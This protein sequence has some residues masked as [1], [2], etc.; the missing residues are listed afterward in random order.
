[1]VASGRSAIAGAGVG[2]AVGD[3]VDT[4]EVAVALSLP[5]ACVGSG[6]VVALG[7]PREAVALDSGDVA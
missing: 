7:L 2:L 3:G 4:A 1:M 6:T 5:I